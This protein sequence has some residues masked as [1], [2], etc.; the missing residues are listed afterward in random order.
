MSGSFF[1]DWITL[2]ISLFNTILLLWL[3]LTVLLDAE[4]RTWDVW[5]AAEGLL[6]GAAFF[7]SHSAILAQGLNTFGAGLDFW[8]HVGWAPVVLSPFA[9]Y[10]VV[11][12]FAGF[13]QDASSDL[14]RRQAPFLGLALLFTALLIILLLLA[15]PLP[16]F[17]QRGQLNLNNIPAIGG[18]PWLAII[19]PV[20]IL[21]CIFLALDALLRPGPTTRLMGQQARRRARPWLV[22]STLVLLLVSILVTVVFIWVSLNVQ[23]YDPAQ[24]ENNLPF[25]LSYFDLI[26]DSLVS[27]AILLIGQAMVVYEVFTGKVLPRRGLRRFWYAAVLLAFL[28]SVIASAGLTADIRPIYTLMTVM[29]LMILYFSVNNR[30]A[31]LDHQQAIARLRPFIGQRHLFEQS[32]SPTLDVSRD[33]DIQQAFFSLCHDILGVKRAVLIVI[34]PL[35]QI[36]PQKELYYPGA[37]PLPSLNDILPILLNDPEKPLPLDIQSYQGLSWALALH[38]ARG[39]TG[40]L[41]LSEKSDDG[42]FTQEEMEMT[43]S[44]AEYLVDLLASAEMGRRL[45]DLQ[46]QRMHESQL[47]D[48]RTRRVLHDDILPR[49]HSVL[50]SLSSDSQRSPEVEESIRSLSDTHRQISD[51]LRESPPA[52]PAAIK[53]RGLIGALRYLFQGEMDGVFE[54]VTW[55]IDPPAEKFFS[56][57]PALTAETL[58]FAAREAIRNSARHGRPAGQGASLQLFIYAELQ[59]NIARIIIEDDGVGLS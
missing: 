45:A 54:R 19:Y 52:P 3:G 22:A 57:L 1:L 21:F 28:V 10:L 39:V 58:F 30:Q 33:G 56:S 42:F 51:L 14:H 9:W 32:F 43:R 15:N 23:C 2:S 7:V 44:A 50:I 36:V 53:S 41:L 13:W 12:W 46:R 20:Y 40:I 34:G 11:L 17:D 24:C 49:L 4:K 35:A 29:I 8:W 47:L 6:M 55:L 31:F 18:I 16:S 5:L 26:I 25:T 48:R 37:G 38:S 27:A 59:N